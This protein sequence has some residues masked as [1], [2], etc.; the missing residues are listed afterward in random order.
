MMNG[1]G[2]GD[3]NVTA[4]GLQVLRTANVN[5]KATAS[6]ERNRRIRSVRG[7]TRARAKRKSGGQPRRI[8][9][10]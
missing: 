7:N 6:G 10:F 3:A 9:S 2:S 4:S 5:V 1:S 8:E